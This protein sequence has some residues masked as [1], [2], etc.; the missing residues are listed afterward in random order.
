MKNKLSLKV[1]AIFSSIVLITCLVM[2]GTS[3]WIN[4]DIEKTVK[5]I[6]HDDILDGY[7]TEVKSEV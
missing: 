6:R 2:L 7:K 3:A 1:T 4:T 5:E